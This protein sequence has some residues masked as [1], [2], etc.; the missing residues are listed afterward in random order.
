[1]NGS[2][3]KSLQ[4]AQCHRICVLFSISV[5]ISKG[6]KNLFYFILYFIMADRAPTEVGN[7]IKENTDLNDTSGGKQPEKTDYTSE[8]C[9]I[10][11]ATPSGLERI[12]SEEA[13]GV[14]QQISHEGKEPDQE[15]D[16]DIV[17]TEDGEEQSLNAEI[18]TELEELYQTEGRSY[19]PL[20]VQ[21]D[22]TQAEIRAPS[23]RYH[24][25]Q[26]TEHLQKTS[27]SPP[28]AEVDNLGTGYSKSNQNLQNSTIRL[29]KS[30]TSLRRSTPHLKV[31]TASLPE[32]TDN[33]Q[34][35]T[36][37]PNRSS[38]SGSSQKNKEDS[39]D[40]Q[41]TPNTGK[42][43]QISFS[44]GSSVP[45]SKKPS[46]GGRFKKF[47]S[48][49]VHTKMAASRTSNSRADQ[50]MSALTKLIDDDANKTKLAKALECNPH[51][52]VSKSYF[53]S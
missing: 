6:E 43:S 16:L 38:S 5:S 24:S 18:P 13:E 41:S 36:E 8:Y 14:S 21:A 52:V 27:S 17:D 45:G 28:P 50:T 10:D 44:G 20:P 46:I 35:L 47:V 19:T 2:A 42:K 53:S 25:P 4:K 1:M 31:S 3:F 11:T 29:Q 33:I 34:T 15:G 49:L 30:A 40:S 9:E 22:N 48:G 26:P 51:A 32:S 12:S 23:A 7:S 37:I 39:T